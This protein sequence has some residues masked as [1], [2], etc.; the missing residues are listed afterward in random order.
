M[1]TFMGYKYIYMNNIYIVCVSCCWSVVNE[2]GKS[3]WASPVQLTIIQLVK[4]LRIER[5]P[6]LQASFKTDINWDQTSST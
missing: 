5:K 6:F 2:P 3:T 4:P 1:V